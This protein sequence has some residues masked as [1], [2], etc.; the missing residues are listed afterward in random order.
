MSLPERNLKLVT[1]VV[2]K[3]QIVMSTLPP[4]SKAPAAARGTFLRRLVGRHSYHDSKEEP[5]AR[6][7]LSPA[8]ESTLYTGP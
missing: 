4:D 3:P 2:Q 6:V 1:K 5:K 8:K 7:I